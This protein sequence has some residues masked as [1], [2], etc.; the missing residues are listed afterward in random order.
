MR[1]KR[2]MITQTLKRWLHKLFAWWP[3]KSTPA[4]GY[5]EP[6]PNGNMGTAQET[7]WRTMVEGPLP[8]AGMMSVAVEQDEAMPEPLWPPV[9]DRSERLVQPTSPMEPEP[10]ASTHHPVVDSSRD[11]YTSSND[12]SSP[13][14]EQQLEFLRYLMQRGLLNEGF[15]EGQVPGQYR[16]KYEK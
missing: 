3:W 6:L 5:A 10:I 16:R 15:S 1:V 9:E 14:F 12:A 7:V 11:A 2:N 13:T 8:Q 4:T